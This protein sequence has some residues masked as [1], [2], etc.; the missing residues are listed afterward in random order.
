MNWKQLPPHI[1]T[2]AEQA[3]TP[4]ELDAWKLSLDGA[5]HRTIA[6]A[7]GTSPSTARDRLASARAKIARALLDSDQEGA[8]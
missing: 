8:A 5:G 1:R 3:C 4:R 2:I 7:L 6:R